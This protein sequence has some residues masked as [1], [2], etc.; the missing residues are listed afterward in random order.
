[1][2][3]QLNLDGTVSTVEE[4]VREEVLALLDSGNLLPAA[5]SKCGEEFDEDITLAL[6]AKNV[7]AVKWIGADPVCLDCYLEATGFESH[8]CFNCTDPVICDPRKEGEDDNGYGAGWETREVYDT[9]WDKTTRTLWLHNDNEDVMKYGTCAE[10]LYR[11]DYA[12]FRYFDC[13]VCNR[14]ISMK[15][16]NNGWHEF[17]REVE[18]GM[19]CLTCY[20]KELVEVGVPREAFEKGTI[21]GM[22]LDT[23]DARENG[24]ETVA[25]FEY[26]HIVSRQDAKEYGRKAM[27]LID[28]GYIVLNEYERMAIGGLEGY[29]TM[30]AKKG[31]GK[32]GKTDR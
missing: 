32:D 28:A 9:P 17:C 27:E 22:F 19:I 7:D 25:G 18:D 2:E 20:E 10:L 30:W 14:T 16:R 23:G 21:P 6:E 15:N 26:C 24:F 31:G 8:E 4:I 29:V 3:L 12:D 5:C 1:M 11:T 13:V